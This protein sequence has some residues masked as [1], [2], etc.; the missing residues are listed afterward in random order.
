MNTVLLQPSDI[1]NAL[2]IMQPIIVTIIVIL[3][4]RF[5][6]NKILSSLTERGT[7]TITTKATIMRFVDIIVGFI[8][9]LVVL[10][11]LIQ[12]YQVFVVVAILLFISFFLFYYE[13]REFV[14]YINLQLLRHLRGRTFEI[15]L[16]NHEKPVY[17]RIVNIE[18]LNSTIEDIYGKRIYVSNSLLVN[19]V[20]REHIPSIEL[21]ITLHKLGPELAS[22]LENILGSLREIDT[23]IFRIDTKK[24]SIEKVSRNSITFRLIV[25]PTS[26][27]IRISDLLNFIELLN[28][29][30]N[31]YEPSIEVI[32]LI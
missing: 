8:I 24:I 21:R 27:P 4:L 6:L 28:N 31:K 10:Q 2:Q 29:L 17:G 23:G 12:P 15:R 11:A 16:P 5:I 32:E 13:L 3:L 25:F 19:A 30:L 20:L 9:I 1:E 18:L 22:A 26:T 7:L 14:A